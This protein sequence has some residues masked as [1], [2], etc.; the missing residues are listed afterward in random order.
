MMTQATVADF[1]KTADQIRNWGRWGD[2]DQLGTLNFITADAV[3]AAATLARRGKVFSLGVNFDSNGPQGTTAPFR[4]NPIHLMTIDGGD[5]AAFAS[6]VRGWDHAVAAGLGTMFD[7]GLMRFNDDYI[8]MPLQ[9][10]T[11]WDALSHVYYEDQLYNGYPAAS[12]TSFGATRL[13]IETTATKGITG[14]G[15]LLDIARAR[16]VPYVDLGQPITPEEL[17]ET[18][19]RQGVELRSGDILLIRTGWWERFVETRDGT[20]SASGLSW[21]CAQW[22]HTR[23]IAAVAADNVAVEGHDNEVEGVF[24]AL[25][26]LCL[27]D[28]GLMF[29]ELWNLAQLAA[30]CAD[31]GVYEFLLVASPLKVT[32]GVGSPLNPVALK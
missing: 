9:A 24:L 28:M 30:D 6:H 16:G 14:R 3:A 2:D 31:D 7:N 19:A 4:T 15:V 18:A 12:V 13:G 5:A 1:R 17:E 21:R 23:E 8:V 22:L 26:C 11:Q 25:H 29:G 10:A 32:G 20:A 27:R